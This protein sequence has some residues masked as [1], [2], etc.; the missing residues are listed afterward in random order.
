MSEKKC[1][2][3]SDPV[4]FEEYQSFSQEFKPYPAHAE[5]F[6]TFVNADEFLKFASKCVSPSESLKPSSSQSSLAT[7]PS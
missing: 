3:C 7:S 5:C 1:V 4:S 2:V 6:D